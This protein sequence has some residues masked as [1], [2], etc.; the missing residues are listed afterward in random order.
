MTENSISVSVRTAAQMLDA[1]ESFVRGEIRQGK[2][3]AKRFGARVSISVKD[4]EAYH[5]NQPDWTPGDAPTAAN[6]ARRS[7]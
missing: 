7:K 2:L 4:L 5:D 1:S 6:T 3:K